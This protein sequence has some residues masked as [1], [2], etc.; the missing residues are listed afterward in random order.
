MCGYQ[1]LNWIMFKAL[2]IVTGSVIH[3]VGVEKNLDIKL[4]YTKLRE[5]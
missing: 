3:I 5:V 1:L 2:F 4:Y